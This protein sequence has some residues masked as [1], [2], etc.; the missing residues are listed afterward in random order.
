MSTVKAGDEGE[1]TQQGLFGMGDLPAG[2]S[3]AKPTK[4]GGAARVMSPVRN[5]VELRAVD[6]ESLLAP[7]H[8]AR[9]VWAFVQALDPGPLH[10]GIKSVASPNSRQRRQ[11]TSVPP[12]A[13]SILG[14]VSAHCASAE[15]QRVRK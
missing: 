1:Q 3:A 8:P 11:A 5:Q 9:T 6:L 12:P 7:D 2:T 15:G 14:R 10:A 13:G 4:A